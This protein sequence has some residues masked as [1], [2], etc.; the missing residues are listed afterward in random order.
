MEGI[1]KGQEKGEDV[2]IRSRA[3]MAWG[4][5]TAT[6]ERVGLREGHR[7]QFLKQQSF[8]NVISNPLLGN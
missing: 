6:K 2:I 3:A 4:T 5:V 7:K 8:E 1:E